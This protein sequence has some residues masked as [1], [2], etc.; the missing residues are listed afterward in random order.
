MRNELVNALAPSSYNN[1]T[2]MKNRLRIKFV[3]P[4]DVLRKAGEITTLEDAIRVGKL[5]RQAKS[6]NKKIQRN[7]NDYELLSSI[8]KE[9][10]PS[11]TVLT[12]DKTST[13]LSR[14]YPIGYRPHLVSVIL[15]DLAENGVYEKIRIRQRNYN[16][17]Y[18]SAFKKI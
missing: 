17:T 11:G 4:D 15:N 5:A 6:T 1:V 8:L 9:E 14:E 18:L 10:V 12:V 3:T 2:P 7:V 13:A 16:E